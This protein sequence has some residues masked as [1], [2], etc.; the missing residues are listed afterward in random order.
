MP[1]INYHSFLCWQKKCDSISINLA[2]APPFPP[3]QNL[4][5]IDKGWQRDPLKEVIHSSSIGWGRE[6][7][8]LFCLQQQH[9][10]LPPWW[11][12]QDFM[13]PFVCSNNDT[14]A[15]NANNDM[16]TDSNYTVT[17]NNPMAASNND[18]MAA[19]NN[20]MKAASNNDTMA[21]NTNKICQTAITQWLHKHLCNPYICV[22]ENCI[23]SCKKSTIF[24]NKNIE[25]T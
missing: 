6:N 20:N 22:G 3:R 2:W 11:L 16:T 21:N 5:I 15:D 13:Q 12:L 18:M 9:Q 4:N 8:R 14:A 23:K 24:E 7:L 25:N 19:S 1:I 10:S 17:E